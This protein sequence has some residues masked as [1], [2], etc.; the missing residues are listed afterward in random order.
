MDTQLSLDL[1]TTTVYRFGQAND[2]SLS[3]FG[4]Y[5]GWGTNYEW[6]PGPTTFESFKD[7]VL[8]AWWHDRDDATRRAY[9]FAYASIDQA[10]RYMD[11]DAAIDEGHLWALDVEL[12]KAYKFPTQ[13]LYIPTGVKNARKVTHDDLIQARR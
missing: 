12:D 7:H 11:V 4:K 8:S 2:H 5:Y 10:R 9:Y 3:T 1:G 6:L 13:A